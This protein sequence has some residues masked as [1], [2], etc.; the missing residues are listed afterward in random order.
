MGQTGSEVNEFIE[1]APRQTRV[2][3]RADVVVAGGGPAGLAA[4]IAAARNGAQVILVERYGYLG[5]SFAIETSS[6]P[7]SSSAGLG[8]QG[9]DG[10]RIIG[11]IAW[12]LMECIKE[13]GGS[14]GPLPRT[15]VSS[16]EGGYLD[17]PYSRFGPQIDVEVL[18]VVALEMVQEAG[19]RL[20]LHTWAVDAVMTDGKLKGVIIQSKSG[21]EALLAETVVDA[22]ADADIAAAAGAPWE[23][24]PKDQ[25]YRMSWELL[26]ANVDT[27]RI[28]RHMREHPEQFAFTMFASDEEQIPS[29]FQRSVWSEIELVERGDI[30]L[31]DDR[32]GLTASHPRAHFKLAI[33]PSILGVAAGFDGDPTDVEDL[34]Q[35]E[36]IARQKAHRS[37]EWLKGL[38]PGLDNAFVAGAYPLGTRES[39]RILGDYV[40]TEADLRQGRRFEDVIGRNNMPLDCHLGGGAWRYELLKGPHDIP[41]RCLLPKGVEGLLVAGRCISCDHIAQSS[42]RKVTACLTTGEAAGTAAALAAKAGVAPRRLDVAALQA[43]LS[44]HGVLLGREETPQYI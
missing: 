38:L 1:E 39:R 12:E 8:F 19:V 42:L 2:R 44:E 5:G 40:V 18:K 26:L 29:G 43:K 30:K 9:V 15:V 35:A 32:L 22:T 31:R 3:A 7:G 13:R 11:G 28:Y 33:R 20:I 4:A 23:K 6:V 16:L 27:D 10:K 25:L 24:L 17:A 41:Y 21:R 34:T 36:I 14:V 37:V